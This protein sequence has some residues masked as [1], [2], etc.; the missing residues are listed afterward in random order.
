M[1]CF[2]SLDVAFYSLFLYGS[3][4]FLRTPLIYLACCF[5]LVDACMFFQWNQLTAGF[6]SFGSQQLWT[7]P[8]RDSWPGSSFFF[9]RSRKLSRRCFPHSSWTTLCLTLAWQTFYLS[10]IKG[11]ACGSLA[12][13]PKTLQRTWSEVRFIQQNFVKVQWA[14]V[15]KNV[16][17]KYAQPELG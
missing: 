16:L 10:V 2:S 5:G 17:L 8:R 15:S 1:I 3:F 9:Q 7:S 13:S 14:C 12:Q 11:M 6:I 4:Y